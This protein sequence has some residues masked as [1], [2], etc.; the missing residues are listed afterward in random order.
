MVQ[1]FIVTYFLLDDAC[2]A[3][4]SQKGKSPAISV[5]QRSMCK[6]HELHLVCDTLPGCTKTL[7][8]VSSSL[9]YRRY[10]TVV[11]FL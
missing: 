7:N 5:G 3:M 6:L 10:P 2:K 11:C 8:L 4:E 9:G 1:Q